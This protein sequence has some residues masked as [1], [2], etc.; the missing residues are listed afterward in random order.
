MESELTTRVSIS[1]GTAP[2]DFTL[3]PELPPEL[4]LKIWGLAIPNQR[5]VHIR[6]GRSSLDNLQYAVFP[7]GQDIPG[8]IS[9]SY[10]ARSVAVKFYTV[11]FMSAVRKFFVL[12]PIEIFPALQTTGE[13]LRSSTGPRTE[14]QIL[15]Q[16]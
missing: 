10:E 1:E 16:M 6:P 3:V 11:I 7:L 8:M 15:S 4:R 9:V 14:S 12:M 2:T 5:V 13:F